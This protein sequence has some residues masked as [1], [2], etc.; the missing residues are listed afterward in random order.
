M[1]FVLETRV[2]GCEGDGNAGVGDEG[3]VVVVTVGHEYVSG[4]HGSG[5][6]SS[7]ADVIG[8]SGMRRKEELV[9]YV[10]CACVCLGAVGR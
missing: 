7:A 4:T 8:M 10:K 1:L 3:G 5:I 2:R 6:A 9:E